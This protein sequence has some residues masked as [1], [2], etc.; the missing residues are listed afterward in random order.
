MIDGFRNK[1][2]LENLTT[3]NLSQCRF[4]YTFLGNLNKLSIPFGILNRTSL[5]LG[6]MVTDVVVSVSSLL[7]N[8]N[9]CVLWLEEFKSPFTR[10]NYRIHLSM[11]CKYHN[12][13][14]DA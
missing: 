9:S 13:D 12:M 5:L 11:F 4:N 7:A 2:S 6:L 14:P 10:R 1:E 8:S 3:N